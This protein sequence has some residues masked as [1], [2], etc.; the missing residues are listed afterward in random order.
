MVMLGIVQALKGAYEYCN[1][2]TPK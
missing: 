1:P 2:P